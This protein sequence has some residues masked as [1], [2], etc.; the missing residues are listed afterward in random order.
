MPESAVALGAPGLDLLQF[1][2]TCFTTLIVVVDP[3]GLV[4]IFAGLT[5]QFDP[6]R[7]RRLVRRAV[8][9]AFAI[10]LV[11]LVVGRALLAY[12]GVSVHAFSISGGI[13]L[14]ATAFPMLFGHRGGLQA[15][16]HGEGAGEDPAVFPLAIPLM[17]GPGTLTTLL[18][19]ASQAG[20]SP[21]ALLVLAGVVTMVF[22]LAWVTLA[23]GQRLLDRLGE[24]GVNV[25]T[26][27]LG[28]L[29]AALAVQ[30]VVNGIRGAF[31]AGAQFAG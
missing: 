8:L 30:F 12:L 4:P 13:L 3:F 18:L 29:L 11:F 16:E 14:F 19:L 7:R 25:V 1:A 21:S 31:P 28:V 26:R 5:A 20:G 27:V 24:R 10:S 23:F 9:I 17:S 15:P 2:L 6:R 22:A